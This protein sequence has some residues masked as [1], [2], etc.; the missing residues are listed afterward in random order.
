MNQQL[1]DDLKYTDQLDPIMKQ[2]RINYIINNKKTNICDII[3]ILGKIDQNELQII[4]NIIVNNGISKYSLD[5]LITI[6]ERLS[7][8]SIYDESRDVGRSVYDYYLSE[9]LKIVIK[10]KR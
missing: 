5:E 4:L 6:C 10:F 3:E 8:N 2:K 7:K 1:G 9:F